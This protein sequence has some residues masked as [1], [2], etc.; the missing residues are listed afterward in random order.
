MQLHLVL[1][2]LLWPGASAFSPVSGLELPALARLLGGGQHRIAGFEPLDRQLAR[3]FGLTADPLPLAA[4]RRRGE[5][6]LPPPGA[7][8]HWLCADPV[9]LSF[10][11][12][13]LLLHEF[14][15][16]ELDGDEATE[17][18]AA[19][20]ET[21]ADLGRFEMCA[22]TRWYLRLA[23]PTRV[24]LYPLNDVAGRPVK[25]F[26]P[27]GDDARLWQ[28]TMNEAQ[29]LLHNH[30]LSRAREEAG[31]RTVNSVWFWGAGAIETTPK[32]GFAAV[33]TLDPLSAG[34]A[35][36]AGLEPAAPDVAAAL[37]EDTL[38]VLDALLKPSQ[39]FDLESWRD[40][41]GALERNW[42]APLADALRAGRLHTLKL[43]APGDRGSLELVVRASDRW[44]FWRK[45][46]DFDALLKSLAPPP[47][48]LP[49]ASA[50]GAPRQADR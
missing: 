12:E 14:R 9:N 38:V 19:L 22:P 7:A 37:K 31:H 49:T 50:G 35:R 4:L 5:P 30:P 32:T 16:Y 24:T 27:E 47:T 26:L 41:L 13:H 8:T 11:R 42:F 48:A 17:L 34:L 1:P 3:L 23:A 33:Q 43:S 45:P 15:E 46:L 10:A 6:H 39:R 28:R 36:A 44:K 21:F 20:N 18:V 29:M 25:H 40:A 2:G